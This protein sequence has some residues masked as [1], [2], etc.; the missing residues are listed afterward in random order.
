MKL[1]IENYENIV[2]ILFE[3]R[4]NLL[5]EIKKLKFI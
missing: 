1:I 3:E 2:K 4:L 5:N